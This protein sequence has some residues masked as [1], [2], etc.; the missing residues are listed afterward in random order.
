[1]E[2]IFIIYGKQIDHMTQRLIAESGALNQIR[3]DDRV[4]I[5]PNLVVSR[6]EWAGVNTDPRVVEALIKQLK[7]YGVH[8]ITIGDGS[9]M[10]YN[11]AKAFEICGYN[12]LKKKY[13]LKLVDLERD[14]FVKR[15]TAIDGPFNH[16]DI[17]QTVVDCDFLINVPVM[18][19]HG[20]TLITCSLKKLKGSHAKGDENRV[21]RP[22]SAPCH[23]S[24]GGCG[25]LGFDRCGWASG[26]SVFRDRAHTGLNGKDDVG[27]QSGGS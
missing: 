4:V 14:R 8:R 27:A 11:A 1:M 25:I 10:G 12:R 18:K 5:K 23:L 19:A 15:S 6:A 20:E 24:I 3:P 2:D 26:G 16:L 17:A 21:S 7:E 9:G 13:N 22:K